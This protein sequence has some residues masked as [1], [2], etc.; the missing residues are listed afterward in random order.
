MRIR[1]A[2]TS[3]LALM[4]S[5]VG[6]G[7]QDT[8]RVSVDSLAERLRRAEQAI[9]LLREQLAAE[10]ESKVQAA[11]R[12]R[13]D[14]FGRRDLPIPRHRMKR[15]PCLPCPPSQRRCRP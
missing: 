13:V 11:T 14:L 9:E 3:V 5:V 2:T 1:E 8:A 4:L 6:A 10:A 7:A 15:D 12:V